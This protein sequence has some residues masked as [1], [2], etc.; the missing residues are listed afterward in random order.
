MGTGYPHFNSLESRIDRLAGKVSGVF[1]FP[2]L[3]VAYRE[4]KERE[5]AKEIIAAYQSVLVYKKGPPSW[6]DII[7]NMAAK[8]SFLSAAGGAIVRPLI[9]Q[10]ESGLAG[11]AIGEVSENSA[12]NFWN[13]KVSECTGIV[14]GE[15]VTTYP[16]MLIGIELIS[17]HG[18]VASKIMFTDVVSRRIAVDGNFLN[19]Y[20]TGAAIER[21]EE[22]NKFNFTY[23]LGLPLEGVGALSPGGP[24]TIQN[25]RLLE[26]MVDIEA[27]NIHFVLS[28]SSDRP[29]APFNAKYSSNGNPFTVFSINSEGSIASAFS[30]R[31]IVG[32]AEWESLFNLC[33]SSKPS[34]GQPVNIE[35]TV[36]R[37]LTFFAGPS[38]ALPD[39][40]YKL[41]ANRLDWLIAYET[42][43]AR[44][45]VPQL[46]SA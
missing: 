33:F 27:G 35:R 43:L 46:S 25:P 5:V 9:V 45:A 30:P 36:S 3:W 16:S 6:N 18:D 24:V 13:G 38:A 32:K 4:G 11:V 14:N 40:A 26:V 37:M 20:V 7:R 8:Y 15:P 29:D 1:G 2:N 41:Q 12:P 31:G 21:K 28:Y 23:S 34:T 39:G 22:G 17:H 10:L 42:S 44:N 19:G